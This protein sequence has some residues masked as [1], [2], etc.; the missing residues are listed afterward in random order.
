MRVFL[1]FFL[2]TFCSLQIKAQVKP[3][4]NFYKKYKSHQN[5][6][7]IKIQ[8]WLLKLATNFSDESD[9]KRLLKKITYLR[10]LIIEEGQ[11]V[12]KSEHH[13]LIKSLKEESFDPLIQLRDGLEK[14]DIL[15][16]EKDKHISDAVV[17]IYGEESFVILSIEGKLNFSDLNDLQFDIDGSEHFKRIPEQ[18]SDLPKA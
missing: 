17:V 3:I 5:T 9:T 16:R 2:M 14:V 7:D 15:I 8:G 6:Y 13:Q 18:K 11:L 1:V 12:G 4:A 10:A